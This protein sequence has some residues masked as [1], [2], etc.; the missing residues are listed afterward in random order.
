[1]SGG[2][3][4][5][6]SLWTPHPPSLSD[7][8]GCALGACASMERAPPKRGLTG[9]TT[10]NGLPSL[11]RVGKSPS[12]IRFLSSFAGPGACCDP[13]HPDWKSVTEPSLLAGGA[14]DLPGCLVHVSEVRTLLSSPKWCSTAMKW[15]APPRLWGPHFC[16]ACALPTPAD[17]ARFQA[18]SLNG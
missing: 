15:M 12:P 1:M 17:Q 4:T 9:E 2:S 14:P 3:P 5:T 7:A 16:S 6:E 18:P 13:P 10:G 11:L 8:T